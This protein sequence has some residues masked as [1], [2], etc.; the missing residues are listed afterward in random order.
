MPRLFA[1]FVRHG[2][3]HQP[4]HVPSAHLPHPLTEDGE[5]H[6]RAGAAEVRERAAELGASIVP[7][8]DASRL[9]RA[10]QTAG[11][12]AQEL[13][14]VLERP[15]VSEFDALAE[16]SVGAAANL[17]LE[18]IERVLEADPRY[19]APPPGWKSQSRF[20]LPLLG[21]ESL[22]EAGRR[23]G[24]HVERRM[25]ALALTAQHDLLKVFVGHGGSFRHAAVHL[26]AM[27]LDD[28]P[29]VSMWHGRPV[30]LERK[31]PGVYAHVAGEWK[32]R[33]PKK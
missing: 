32:P 13:G 15:S 29:R 21:A 2:H 16:R 5:A 17:T 30:I 8:I 18:E 28:A 33:K 25:T 4:E 14:D 3:Y 9:L 24:K 11:L 23:V 6:A 31:E 22:L 12:L 10:F 7:E 1:A 26:R 27:D 20:K 19:E